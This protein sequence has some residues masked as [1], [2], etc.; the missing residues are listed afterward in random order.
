M[1]YTKSAAE[2]RAERPPLPQAEGGQVDRATEW[3]STQIPGAATHATDSRTVAA[4]GSA[5]RAVSGF[6]C[7]SRLSPAPATNVLLLLKLEEQLAFLSE[8][9]LAQ[10]RFGLA[11]LTNE[12]TCCCAMPGIPSNWHRMAH[13]RGPQAGR[14]RGGR[15]R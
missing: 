9:L 13:Q 10:G 1:P 8:G 14:T 7:G 4:V 3:I 12:P 2:E 11:G 15:H 6:A 5:D